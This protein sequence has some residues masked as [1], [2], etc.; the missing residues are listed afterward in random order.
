MHHAGLVQWVGASHPHNSL[1][2]QAVLIADILERT[3]GIAT[4]LVTPAV[5]DHRRVLDTLCREGRTLFWHYGGFD[6]NLL[7]RRNYRRVVMVYHNITPARYFWRDE[8]AIGLLSLVGRLQLAGIA[9]S[10][11]WITMSRY[12]ADELTRFGARRVE[13]C[14]NILPGRIRPAADK[15]IEPTLL[16]VGRISPNKNTLTLLEVAT[17]TA[18]R[19]NRPLHLV[20]VGSSKPGSQHGRRFLERVRALAGHPRLRIRIL[21]G[22]EEGELK[23]QYDQAWLYVSTSMHEGFGVPACES[24]AAGTPALYYPCG[25]QE[26]ILDGVGL[27]DPPSVEAFACRIQALLESPGALAELL[28]TQQTQVQAFVAPEI[29]S[30]VAAIYGNHLLLT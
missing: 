12:N 21:Q 3:F 11:P 20:V 23:A 26:S 1:L 30:R 24:I 16:F 18:D 9:R 22:L 2:L 7:V 17:R 13:L 25:G 15:A 5:P 27:V 29:E 19:M 14:P 4:R 10:H 28:A 6:R 8:P